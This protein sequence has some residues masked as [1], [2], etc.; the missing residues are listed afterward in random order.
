MLQT[1]I[2]VLIA[3]SIPFLLYIVCHPLHEAPTSTKESYHT[4]HKP[5]SL[6]PVIY[7]DAPPSYSEVI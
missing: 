7:E 5:V 6:L 4:D 3:M 2:I 1:L